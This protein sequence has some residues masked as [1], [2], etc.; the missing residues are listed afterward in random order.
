MN[1]VCETK[2]ARPCSFY[3]LTNYNLVHLFGRNVW[4]GSPL[5]RVVSSSSYLKVADWVPFVATSLSTC[6]FGIFMVLGAQYRRPA[7]QLFGVTLERGRPDV[8]A[9]KAMQKLFKFYKE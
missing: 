4:F 3:F 9:Q 2:N 8:V 6:D 7:I 5:G 1:A